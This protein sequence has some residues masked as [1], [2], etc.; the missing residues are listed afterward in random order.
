[1]AEPDAEVIIDG[2]ERGKTPL[3]GPLMVSAGTDHMI[4]IDRAGEVLHERKV[5]VAGQ[6]TVTVDIA[7]EA[8]PE[9]EPATAGESPAEPNPVVAEPPAP[10]ASAA[11]SRKPVGRA[12]GFASLGVGAALLVSGA[13]TGG[14]ALSQYSKLKDK[15]PENRCPSASEKDLSDR[16]DGLALATDILIPTGAVIGAVGVILLVVS[17]R[18]QESQSRMALRPVLGPEQGGLLLEGR[19]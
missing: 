2:N 9:P 12:L 18:Q 11:P 6:Q 16:A 15:C 8:P 17:K 10:L 1:L 14:V 19:F 13:V 7:K 3:P 5:R 4:R